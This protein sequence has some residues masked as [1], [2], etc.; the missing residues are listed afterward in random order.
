MRK[1]YCLSLGMS[2]RYLFSRIVPVLAFLL[3]TTGSAVHAQ[4]LN[5]RVQI[6][7]PQVQNTNK[8]VLDVLEKAMSDF[9]NRTS[10]SDRTVAPQERIDCSFVVTVTSW[11]GSSNFTAQAQIISTRPV[12]N[13]SYNSPV[14]SIADN[15]FDF[16]YDEGQ[17]M[18][19]SD[20]QYMSNLTSLLAYYAYVIVG[21]DADTF[22]PSAGT[23]YY[24]QAQAIV[25]NA[26]NTGFSG[27]RSMEGNNNRFW[28]A[29]NLLDRRYQPLRDFMYSFYLNGLDRMV[30]DEMA[31]RKAILGL[32]PRLKDVDRLAQGAM[33]NQV[34]F[35]AKSDELVGILSGMAPQE[36]AEAFNILAA[37]DPANTTKYESLRGR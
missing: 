2:I 15:N 31:A 33:L 11:D 35:T 16:T 27:W 14:L 32:L 1:P 28:L 3:A 23:A 20:Q 18:D 36:K 10:W 25:N 37:V 34:F 8:R 30:D 6:L 12:Y 24:R 26:Q 21:M 5:A 17:M 4:D 9:L 19:Y 7:S 29:N 22:S 13:T